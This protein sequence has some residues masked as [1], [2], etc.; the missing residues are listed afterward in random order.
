MAERESVLEKALH[1]AQAY[2]TRLGE[3]PVASTATLE[4]LRRDLAKPLSDEGVSPERA[5]DELVEDDSAGLVGSAGGRFFGWVIGGS[6]PVATAADRLTSVSDQSAALYACSPAASVVE[7]VAGAWLKDILGIP[8]RGSF[9]FVTGCQMAHVTCLSAVRGALL[10][11]CGW[12]VAEQGLAG[13]PRVRILANEHRHGSI[14]RAAGLLG[15]GRSNIEPLA[16]DE[17]GRVATE[18]RCEAALMLDVDPLGWSGA[19]VQARGC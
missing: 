4:A 6:L 3:Q 17:I 18:A 13:A 12:D 11:K 7:E 9:A 10:R 5:I 2:I 8:S 19:K 14:A 16:T 1:H 15:L